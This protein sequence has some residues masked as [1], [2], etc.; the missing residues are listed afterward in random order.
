M[1]E[2]YNTS[3]IKAHLKDTNSERSWVQEINFIS[4][5][6]DSEQEADEYTRDQINIWIDIKGN[7]V[8]ETN[9]EL[10]YWEVF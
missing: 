10:S 3:R 2:F 4:Y 1:T 5:P 8:Y 7:D 6:H 9:L